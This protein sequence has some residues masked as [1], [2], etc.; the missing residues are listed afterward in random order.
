MFG[1]DFEMKQ[2]FF[3]D[4]PLENKEILFSIGEISNVGKD[5]ALLSTPSTMLS[6]FDGPQLRVFPMPFEEYRSRFAIAHAGLLRGDSYLL[7][8]TLRTPIS[9][10]LSLEQIVCRSKD[11]EEYRAGPVPAEVNRKA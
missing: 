7:N 2:G 6:G 11:K 10:N 4:H 8:L 3:I 5:T 1:I 9:T